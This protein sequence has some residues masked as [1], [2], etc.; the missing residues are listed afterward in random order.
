ME[1]IKSK[2][3]TLRLSGSL[4]MLEER[5]DYALEN[6][7][8]Y[9]DF[10]EL[11]L[12]DECAT[13]QANAYRRGLKSSG[14][15][16][17]KRID[18]YE[19]SCQPELDRGRLM[20]LA[21]CRYIIENQNIILMGK[22]GTGKTHL[23]N[24]LGLKALEKGYQVIF[25]HAHQLIEQLHRSRAAGSYSR[26]IRKLAK[27]DLLIIDELGFRKIPQNGLEDFFEIIRTRYEHGSVIITTNR[28]FADWEELFGDRIMA[29]AIID[30]LVH[31]AHIFKMMGDSYRLKGFSSPG[32][33]AGTAEATL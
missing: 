29:S 14:I 6:K 26:M 23:A 9:L 21:A 33:E 13:R 32:L 17:Q 11:V 15:N 1:N 8:S 2:L 22:P 12:E 27:A 19:F 4:A 5:N 3:R 16:E 18:N 31:H 7:V 24:A 25:S 20:D 28:K 30:R 10:L